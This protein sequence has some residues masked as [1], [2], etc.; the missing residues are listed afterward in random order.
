MA[1]NA[2]LCRLRVLFIAAAP[3]ERAAGSDS[4]LNLWSEIRGPL[5]H[6]LERLQRNVQTPVSSSTQWDALDQNASELRPAFEHLERVAAQGSVI[7]DDDTY[8]RI[9]AF[10]GERA[11]TR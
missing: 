1:L 9:L 4:Y 8:V 11:R 5:H 7:H 3:F 6:R 10:M 2:A